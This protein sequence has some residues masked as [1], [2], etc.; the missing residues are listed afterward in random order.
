MREPQRDEASS[1]LER[2]MIYEPPWDLNFVLWS[3]EC[4]HEVKTGAK[5]ELQTYEQ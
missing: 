5:V 3:L 1:G 2:L 4:R